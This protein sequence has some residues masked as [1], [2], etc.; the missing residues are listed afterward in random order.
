MN[1]CIAEL[2]KLGDGV[3]GIRVDSNRRA[4]IREKIE[5][6]LDR[7]KVKTMKKRIDLDELDAQIKRLGK[8]TPQQVVNLIRTMYQELDNPDTFDYRDN[9]IEW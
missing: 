1:P 9:V 4:E 2:V 8:P 7:S 3:G 6:L 5:A